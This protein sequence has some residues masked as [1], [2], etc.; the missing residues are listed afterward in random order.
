MAYSCGPF[1]RNGRIVSVHVT[2]YI[3]HRSCAWGQG[4]LAVRKG[5]GVAKKT[6]QK[7]S[8]VQGEKKGGKSGGV[9]RDE[10]YCSV[11]LDRAIKRHQCAPLLCDLRILAVESALLVLLHACN[12][13]LQSAHK[14]KQFSGR[15]GRGVVSGEWGTRLT[16]SSP[17]RHG[18]CRPSALTCQHLSSRPR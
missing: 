11:R 7:M 16:V 13:F 8:V 10:T 12:L 18:R 9:G 14:R 15:K 5:K 2:G 17:V 4:V 6:D 3:S 1:G